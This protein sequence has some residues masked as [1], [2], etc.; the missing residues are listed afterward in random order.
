MFGRRSAKNPDRKPT[1]MRITEGLL[2]VFGPAQV[3]DSTAPLREATE[4][5][6]GR[7]TALRTE[8]TRVVAPNGHSYVVA[9]PVTPDPTQPDE[10]A[11]PDRTHSPG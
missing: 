11:R 6:R 2:P 8:L 1:G 7:D 4:A 3:G 5:E 9:T 10:A